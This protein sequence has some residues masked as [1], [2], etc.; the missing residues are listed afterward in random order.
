MI[1]C[2]SCFQL[3]P[4]IVIE[5]NVIIDDLS[6]LFKGGCFDLSQSFF[7]QMSKEVL[8][9][10]IVQA[11]ATPRHGKCNVTCFHSLSATQIRIPFF[12]FSSEVTETIRN[13]EKW[14]HNISAPSQHKL[15]F[16]HQM[17]WRISSRKQITGCGFPGYFL[18][19]FVSNIEE[20]E[21]W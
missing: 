7:F 2:L 15:L 4:F 16:L 20:R 17:F 18:S 10:D 14:F 6:S 3:Y 8:H 13:I 5:A 11:I 12:L 21:S 1:R 19:P 9:W